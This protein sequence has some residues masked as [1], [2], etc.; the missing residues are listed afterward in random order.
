VIVVNFGVMKKKISLGGY[1][2]IGEIANLN[3]APITLLIG[4]NGS[5][6][7][8][9]VNMVRA[10]ENIVSE[11]VDKIEN[12]LFGLIQLEWKKEELLEFS[13]SIFGVNKLTYNV[14]D[15]LE[16]PAGKFFKPEDFNKDLKEKKILLNF[17]I[18]LDF[19]SDKFEARFS[20]SLRDNSLL[21]IDSV[22]I[23]NIN[24]GNRLMS[25]SMVVD[26]TTSNPNKKTVKKYY[27]ANIFLDVN[28]VLNEIKNK[29]IELSKK[30][31][32]VPFDPDTFDWNSNNALLEGLMQ[33]VSDNMMKDSVEAEKE[34]RQIQDNL[35]T[36]FNV[37]EKC[38][39]N[40]DE[41]YNSP[42]EMNY[43]FIRMIDLLKGDGLIFDYAKQNEGNEHFNENSQLTA[44]K[45]FEREFLKK[46]ESGNFNTIPWDF[47]ALS[48]FLDRFEVSDSVLEKNE[49]SK[50]SLNVLG[51]EVLGLSPFGDF[52]I[53]QMIFG[54]FRNCLGGLKNYFGDHKFIGVDRLREKKNS[55]GNFSDAQEFLE[56]ICL[57][58]VWV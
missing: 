16:N 17:P 53:N 30:K 29:S 2:A 9:V 43:N 38:V 14:F 44:K 56:D 27:S 41:S 10:V 7:S 4:P 32:F 54:N 25:V 46:I 42:K 11:Q 26:F 22:E 35:K 1:K 15:F 51:M 31:P 37:A 58:R 50:L 40:N 18:F 20:Y 24:S 5:G 28:F 19:F 48:I 3:L 47:P 52:I 39:L 6:K 13:K 55:V 45:D 21:G 57:K 23:I 12:T 36:P 8:S 33:Q 34:S 49:I